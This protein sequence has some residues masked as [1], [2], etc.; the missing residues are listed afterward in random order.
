MSAPNIAYVAGA[1]VRGVLGLAPDAAGLTGAGLMAYGAG[2]V[3]RPAEFI[4]AGA[5]LLAAAIFYT[6]RG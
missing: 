6:R 3:Y 1:L 4:V 5:L 2:M